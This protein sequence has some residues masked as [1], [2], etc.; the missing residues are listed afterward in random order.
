MTVSSEPADTGPLAATG[1]LKLAVCGSGRWARTLMR[2][3]AAAPDLELAAVISARATIPEDVTHGAPVFGDWRMAA[4]SMDLDGIML[5]L[6][7]EH[8]PAVAEKIM[9]SGLPLF[10]EKPLALNNEAAERLVQAAGDSGFVGLVDHLHLF[11]P[12]FRE[13]VRQVRNRGAVCG[14]TSVSG[15]RGPY[16]DSWSVCW[17]WAPHDVAMVLTVMES[18]P[19]SVSARVVEQIEDGGRTFMNVRL[20]LTFAN[21]A[22]A[23]IT[24]GNAFDGRRREFT[25]AI[26]DFTLSYTESPD[27]ERSLVMG[28]GDDAQPVPVESVPPLTAA[29]TEFAVRI[30]QR[31]GGESDLVLGANVVRVISAAEL[32]ISKG[33]PVPLEVPAY[34]AKHGAAG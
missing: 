33:V 34:D 8:Q 15:N 9:A 2:N 13:L 20:T 19:D 24:T 11:A 6:S 17:D 3:I 16:R 14:I 31:A 27:N 18:V 1:P 7:P 32:S 10:L 5:A 22:V 4:S 12:E 26:D 23:D 25:V 30:R 28:H 29:L 21:G